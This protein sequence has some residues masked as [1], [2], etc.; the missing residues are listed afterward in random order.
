MAKDTSL[1][2]QDVA[3]WM[4]RMDGL[5]R[6]YEE[7]VGTAW[8]SVSEKVD[9]STA[10]AQDAMLHNVNLYSAADLENPKLN[11]EMRANIKKIYIEWA[12]SISKQ[13]G[14]GIAQA[15]PTSGR[16][17]LVSAAGQRAEASL[18][19]EAPPAPHPTDRRPIGPPLI[20]A[21]GEVMN[22][23]GDFIRDKFKGKVPTANEVAAALAEK[24]G[25]ED[26]S[27]VENISRNLLDL[28]SKHANEMAD[29]VQNP[30]PG[31]GPGGPAAAVRL[32]EFGNGGKGN[33]G[34]LRASVES[35]GRAVLRDTMINSYPDAPRFGVVDL[36]KRTLIVMSVDKV[37]A[38]LAGN[39][40]P[41]GPRARVYPIPLPDNLSDKEAQDLWP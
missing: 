33:Q 22:V 19:V 1:D 38:N 2:P 12:K 14:I 35:H 16:D 23:V 5:L 40:P 9:A 13:L 21:G 10:R 11:R 20:D 3:G 36:D 4:T 25:I 18:N 26:D 28:V 7:Q 39:Q 30:R 32:F 34:A 24:A 27:S 31:S 37:K 17:P 15:K 6:Q 29:R 8:F 41:V